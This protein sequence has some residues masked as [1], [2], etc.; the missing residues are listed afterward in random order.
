MTTG[1]NQLPGLKEILDKK[2]LV[3]GEVGSGRLD[4]QR[5][6]KLCRW[7]GRPNQLATRGAASQYK[8]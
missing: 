3:Y 5:L 2:A 4:V 7:C 6:E 1:E 8:L